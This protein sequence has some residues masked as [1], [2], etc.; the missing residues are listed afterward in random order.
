L[1]ETNQFDEINCG[2]IMNGESECYSL[3]GR[4]YSNII[5]K[6]DRVN[7]KAGTHKALMLPEHYVYT[8]MQLY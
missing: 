2:I 1:L 7:T 4:L 8:N 5:N 6:L 3:K